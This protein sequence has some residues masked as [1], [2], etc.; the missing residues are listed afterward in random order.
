MTFVDPVVFLRHL[1]PPRARSENEDAHH[2]QDW[3]V[4]AHQQVYLDYRSSV[5]AKIKAL[6]DLRDRSPHVQ[7]DFIWIDTDRAG[8]DKLGLRL[9]LP[10]KHGKAAVRLAPSGC[11]RLEPRFIQMDL[12][13]LGDAI[14]RMEQ[15]IRQMPD[16]SNAELNRFERLRPLLNTSGTLANLSRE[17][18]DFLL[19]ETLSFQPRP[20]LVSSLIASGELRPGLEKIL[21]RQREFVDAFNARIRALQSLDVAP[22]VKPLPQDY[23]PLFMSCPR[24]GRRLRLRL[25]R[26]GKTY[27][28]CAADSAGGQHRYELGQTNLTMEQ[29]D[30]HVRWSPDVTLP[31]LVNDR[32]SG[33][34]AGKSSALYMLVFRDVMQKVMDTIP[35]PVLVPANWDVFPDAF[36][37]LVDAYLTGRSL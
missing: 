17:F 5:V 12:A 14:N 27:F 18:T 34:V 13:R 29:L 2:A 11:E 7:P 3:P 33:M 30:R 25:D 37:S 6:R 19:A 16:N 32:Y 35:L 22:Q 20:V 28:A 24:D 23:L 10:A 15:L 36:D 21:N 26:V 1:R 4:Y 9:Y 31:M 8:S